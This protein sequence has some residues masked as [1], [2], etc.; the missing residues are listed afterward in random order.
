[1]CSLWW[2]M[3]TKML[4]IKDEDVHQ[5]WHFSLSDFPYFSFSQTRVPAVPVSMVTAARATVARRRWSQPTPVSVQKATRGRGVTRFSQT[6]HQPNGT[7]PAPAFLS[8]LPLPPPPPLLPLNHRP[9]QLYHL[10]QPHQ[11]PLCSHG[12]PNLG[13]G[14]WWCRGRQTGWDRQHINLRGLIWWF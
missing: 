6:C 1:M 5:D 13:R 9:Q 11:R 7:P 2:F 12:N 8:W 3:D 14:C 4:K 10:R